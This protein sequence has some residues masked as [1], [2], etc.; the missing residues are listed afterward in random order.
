MPKGRRSTLAD[1][2]ER[3]KILEALAR[4][5]PIKLLA[6]QHNITTW[7]LYRWIAAHRPKED[8]EKRR[9]LRRLKAETLAVTNNEATNG[10]ALSCNLAD[11]RVQRE[12]LLSIQAACIKNGDL[13]QAGFISDCISR[14]IGHC[15]AIGEM[16]RLRSLTPASITREDYEKLRTDLLKAPTPAASEHVAKVLGKFEAKNSAVVPDE[17]EELY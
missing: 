16:A 8:K 17:Y 4:R 14:N 12:R 2:P 7:V 13:R 5:V 15:A 10:D 3:E 6:K 11:L 1:H 9:V